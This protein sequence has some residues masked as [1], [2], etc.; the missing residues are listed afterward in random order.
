MLLMRSQQRPFL[1]LSILAFV[2]CA[3]PWWG[4]SDLQTQLI[5]TIHQH[6]LGVEAVPAPQHKEAR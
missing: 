1:A 5:E 3:I 6:W 2:A 4:I